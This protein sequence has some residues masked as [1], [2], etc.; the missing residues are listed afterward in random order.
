M[1]IGQAAAQAG[2]N[3]KRVRHYEAVGLIPKASRT[4][5]NYRAYSAND[6]HSLRFIQHARALGFSI[7]EIRALLG[8]WRNRRRPS[9][10]VK[11]LVAQQA[12]SLR[13][14]ILELEAMLQSLEHLARHCHGDERQD[15]PI[16]EG[17]EAGAAGNR[18]PGRV[19]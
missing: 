15:C 9:R 12:E 11:R 13:A 14:R 1:N 19:S 6:V 5:G 4:F 18:P 2:M 8:L 17:L 7:E 16:L 3:A 10:E